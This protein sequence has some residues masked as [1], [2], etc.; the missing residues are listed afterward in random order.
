MGNPWDPDHGLSRAELT[1]R[2][3]R[4]LAQGRFTGALRFGSTPEVRWFD[5]GWDSDVFEARDDGGASW[6]C[7]VPKRENVQPWIR[8]EAE[9][10]ESIG[11]AGLDLAPRL[12]LRGLS[13]ELPYEW[14]ALSV[15][16]GRPL[17]QHLRDVDPAALGSSYGALLR[18]FHDLIPVCL[19]TKPASAVHR[20]DAQVKDAERALAALRRNA[21]PD[22]AREAEAMVGRA[23]RRAPEDVPVVFLHGDL[24]PEHVFLDLATSRAIGLIDWADAM[25]GDPAVDFSLIGWILG[26]RFLEAAV[27]AYGSSEPERLK[28]RSARLGVMIGIYDVDAAERGAPN[29]PLAQRV[30][31][32]ET[33][34]AEG[35]FDRI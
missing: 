23:A 35:W 4:S 34:A 8:K 14:I 16:P 24:F 20:L 10:L 27:S 21:S 18:S 6:L 1:E 11:N 2:L 13:G 22:V 15:A 17:L 5:E 29:V 7:K 33:R 32:V 31:V 26:D 25:W 28:E 9:V 30:E 3:S 12:G 19:G